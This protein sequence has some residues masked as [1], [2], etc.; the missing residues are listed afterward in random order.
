MENVREEG[1][2]IATLVV[3]VV[4]VLVCMCYLLIFVNP[5]VALNPFKPPLATPTAVALGLQRTWTPTFTSTPTQTLTPTLTPTPTRT[6]TVTPTPTKTPIVPTATTTRRPPT[7]TPLPPTAPPTPVYDFRLG[8]AVEEHENCGTWY[9]S[10]TVW[11]S[12]DPN[13]GTRSGVLVRVWFGGQVQGTATTGSYG[14]TAGYWEWFFGKGTAG[15]GVVAVVD[16]NGNLL[17]PQV[18]FH[19]TANCNSGQGE[20]VN[21]VIIDFVATR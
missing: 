17:S 11:N 15:N 19:F 12:A 3:V 4:T 14:K 20:A 1:Y 18:P 9:L 7:R 13:Q 5:Q 21:Q 16:S 2:Q 6:P 8:R 10:G